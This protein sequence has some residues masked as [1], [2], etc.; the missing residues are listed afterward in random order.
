MPSRRL[1]ASPD[2]VIPY[3]EDLH[4]RGTTLAASSA[5]PSADMRAVWEASQ[6]WGGLVFRAFQRA[7]I[8]PLE[9]TRPY[10]MA[11]V[12]GYPDINE[13]PQTKHRKTMMARLA[14]LTLAIVAAKSD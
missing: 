14:V 12:D 7:F 4:S 11:G 6:A 3:L 10:N 13:T 5:D 2:K 9:F 1:K 8:D